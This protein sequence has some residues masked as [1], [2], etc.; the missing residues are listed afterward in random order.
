[1]TARIDPRVRSAI[2][3][4]AG[5]ALALTAAPLMRGWFCVPTG[6]VGAVTV[7][8]Y[9]KGYDYAVV[10][11]IVIASFLG[12]WFASAPQILSTQHSALSTRVWIG[13]V[14]VFVLML[15]IHDHPFVI[16]DPFHEGEHLTPALLFRDGA[17]PFGDVF[18]LHGLGVDGGL[19]A[20]VLGD[21]PSP[22]HTR[23]LETFLDAA[24]LALLVPI[25]AEICATTAGVWL[26]VIAAICALGAGQVPV[27]PYFRLAPI[28]LAALGLL[29]YQRTR[30]DRDL[31]L[32]FGASTL[33]VLWSL[34]SGVYA[35]TA[36]ALATLLL[37]PQAKRA[38]GLTAIA[39]ALPIALLLA[40]RADVTQFFID[41]F[42]TIPRAIDAVW[43][44]P[45]R[46]RFD[47]ETLRYY[48]PPAIFGWL[49]ARGVRERDTRMLVIAIVSLVA[50][51]TAAGRCSWSHTRYGVPILGVI[52]VAFMLEPLIIGRRR[53][54]ATIVIVAIALYVDFVPNVIAA[55]R[56]IAGWPARQRHEG[57]VPYPL[58]AG[59]GIYTTPDDARDLAALAAVVN[60]TPLDA[61]IL[62]LANER[63]AYYL[64]QRRPAVRCPDV[65]MLSAPPLMAEAMRQLE[66]NPPA[67]VIV[68]GMAAVQNFDGV[69]TRQRVPQLYAWVD[70]HY[71]RRVQAGRFTVALP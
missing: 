64:L 51:R 37:R 45:A 65:A 8:N 62:D 32:A 5:G 58:P 56:L 46:N 29:R 40:L 39:V 52:L 30:R 63:V 22:K 17:R 10:A 49:L 1:V 26:A 38:I 21:P 12:A 55:S 3:A 13:M 20:L 23:R 27:F 31:M 4:V 59:R 53:S 6:G 18:V 36:T 43:S 28:F 34:D 14:M 47:L 19:D 60:T 50:F 9:P 7:A 61:P 68:D 15:F 41:S 44:L 33:G 54:A 70:A 42:V 24:S 71:P 67:C 16:M 66:A 2:G 69:P 35:L 11:L 25:A 48:L 57:L